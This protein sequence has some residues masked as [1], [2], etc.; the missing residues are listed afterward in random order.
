VADRATFLEV[1]PESWDRWFVHA[2]SLLVHDDTA[3]V[4]YHG[5][6]VKHGHGRK[7]KGRTPNPT[8]PRPRGGGI[9]L[10][11]LPA[12][13]FVALSPDSPDDEAIVEMHPLHLSG[14]DLLLNA[15]IGQIQVELLDER[16][17]PIPGFTAAESRLIPHDHLRHRVLWNDCPLGSAPSL[18]PT[19]LRFILRDAELYAFQ[20]E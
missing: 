5:W 2:G 8:A 15:E 20:I 9:G 1:G 6:P 3:H 14:T 11:T 10:A 16:G 12:D 13:R 17:I 19:S 4:Y 7:N 18:N